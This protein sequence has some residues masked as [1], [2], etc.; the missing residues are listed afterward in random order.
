[1]AQTRKRYTREFKTE[2]ERRAEV[3]EE[4]TAV[5][6]SSEARAGA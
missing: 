3:S 2:A 4:N 5:I 6:E 1:M